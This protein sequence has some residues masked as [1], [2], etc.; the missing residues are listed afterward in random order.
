MATT[1]GTSVGSGL[2]AATPPRGTADTRTLARGAG[3]G[4]RLLRYL[5]GIVGSLVAW[6]VI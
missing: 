3:P 6:Y 4:N 2:N 5:I 1:D